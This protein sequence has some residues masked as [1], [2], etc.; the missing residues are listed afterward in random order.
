MDRKQTTYYVLCQPASNN[1]SAVVSYMA[2]YFK[3]QGRYT[4]K[5]KDFEIGDV[6]FFQNSKGLSH[7]GWG[8]DWS[9]S[10]KT[11]TTIEGNKGD[12]VAYGTYSYS[13]VGGYIAGFGKPR[14]TDDLTRKA[15]LEYAKSQVGYTEG[16]NNWNKYA[17]ELDK[18]DYFAGCGK[19]QN[20][21]WCAVFICDSAYNAY[22]SEAKPEPAP[23]P[24]PSPEPTP[25]PSPT[26]YVVRTNGGTLTLRSD[27]NVSSEALAYI[28]NGSAVKVSE[29]VKGE[30]INYNTDWAHIPNYN[31]KNGFASCNYL[32]KKT[33][34][35]TYKV[36]TNSGSPLAL[37]SAPSAKSSCLIWIPNGTKLEVDKFVDGWGH[38]S[39]GGYTGYSSGTYLKKV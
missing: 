3:K 38:T 39:Y 4:T 1:C 36:K 5:L 35:E 31:G 33:P 14:Y 9:D 26:D 21:P 29:I 25:E 7:V 17:D 22:S 24:T 20:L 23:E 16:A 18:V 15:V 32:I 12:K 19:K 34:K 30:P 27:H 2:D 10:K 37:R 11:I 13:E 6:V 28:P 8:V